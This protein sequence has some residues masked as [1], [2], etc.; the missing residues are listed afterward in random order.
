MPMKKY[1][2]TRILQ[3]LNGDGIN[4]VRKEMGL[5]PHWIEGGFPRGI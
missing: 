4:P 1:R 2:M 5:A 3:M